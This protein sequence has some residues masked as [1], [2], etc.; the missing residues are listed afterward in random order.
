MKWVYGIKNKWFTTVLLSIIL[1]IILLNNFNESK[2]SEL[3]NKAITEIYND[4]LV[5]EGYI[6]Q[7]TENLH[8][9]IENVNNEKIG[10]A[11]KQIITKTLLSKIQEINSSY[12]KTQL[13]EEEKKE[14]NYFSDLCTV[15]HN[16]LNSKD[17]TEVTINSNKAIVVLKKLSNIQISEGKEIINKTTKLFQSSN[18]ASKFEIAMLVIIALIIQALIFSSKTLQVHQPEEKQNLN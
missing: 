11:E 18:I 16:K 6:L 15:I 14:F 13:T 17:F 4:R 2:N 7:L 12:S 9:I 10:E 8:T 1:V 3:L 5:V